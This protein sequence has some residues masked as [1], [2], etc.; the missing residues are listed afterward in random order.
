MQLEDDWSH[1]LLCIALTVFFTALGTWKADLR[2][3]A[4]AGL[5]GLL[6][7]ILTFMNLT[8]SRR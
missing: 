6:I 8:Q 1:V 3:F 4:A 2:A 5:F 7:V